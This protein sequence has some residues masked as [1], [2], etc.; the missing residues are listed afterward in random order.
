MN[1][2][3]LKEPRDQRL[4]ILSTADFLNFG[5][6]HIAYIKPVTV[7]GKSMYAVHAADGTA[8]GM[9]DTVDTAHVVIRQ[10]DMFAVMLQ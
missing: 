1:N 8:I 3:N 9:S 5:A 7:E 4:K 10:N 6:Q 2:Q